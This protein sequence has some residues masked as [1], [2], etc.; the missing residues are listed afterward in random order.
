[1]TGLPVVAAG[2]LVWATV[3]VTVAVRELRAIRRDQTDKTS[4]PDRAG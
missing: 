4:R 2:L 3:L 1:V